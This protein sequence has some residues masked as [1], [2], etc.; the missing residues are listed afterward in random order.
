MVHTKH[1]GGICT[2]QVMR[3]AMK[4]AEA[5]EFDEL[6]ADPT[7]PAT[8]LSRALK[9]SGYEASSSVLARHRSKDCK[10]GR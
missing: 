2:V 8:A 6:L 1:A 9:D 3:Q 7:V 4:P 10:C 5:E